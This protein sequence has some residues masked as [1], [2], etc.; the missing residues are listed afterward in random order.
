MEITAALYRPS[1]QVNAVANTE[2]NIEE[3][4]GLNRAKYR[5]Q[6]QE[7]G[8]LIFDNLPANTVQAMLMTILNGYS[9]LYSDD[10]SFQEAVRT[11]AEEMG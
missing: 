2:R 8:V 6:G 1:F 7:L 4:D 9:A 5:Q 3:K 11:I 10:R